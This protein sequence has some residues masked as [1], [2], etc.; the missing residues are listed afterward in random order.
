MVAGGT[1]DGAGDHLA[2]RRLLEPQVARAAVLANAITDAPGDRFR[3]PGPAA[4]HEAAKPRL[5]EDQQYRGCVANENQPPAN[6]GRFTSSVADAADIIDQL[7][8]RVL[9][10]TQQRAEN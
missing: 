2:G 5:V 4:L 3:E 7:R 6:P 9:G 1:L 10:A 8:F